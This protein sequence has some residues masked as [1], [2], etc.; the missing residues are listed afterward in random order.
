MTALQRVRETI[1]GTPVVTANFRRV[2]RAYV[3]ETGEYVRGKGHRPAK[4]YKRKM[5]KERCF[6]ELQRDL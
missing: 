2:I 1:T 5:T 4:L 6:H 3:E